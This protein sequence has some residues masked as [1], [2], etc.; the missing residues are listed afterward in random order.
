MRW[1]MST[2]PRHSGHRPALRAFLAL[3]AVIIRPPE[4]ERVHA[5]GPPATEGRRLSRLDRVLDIHV[6]NSPRPP[7]HFPF[8][9]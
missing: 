3:F 6:S 4:G 2:G 8:P 7:S 5:G 1:P 9:R